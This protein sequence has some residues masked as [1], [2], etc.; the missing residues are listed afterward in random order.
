MILSSININTNR[1]VS[2]KIRLCFWCYLLMLI[3]EGAIRKWFLPGLSDLFLVIRD[4]IVLYVIYLSVK[5]RLLKD[6]FIF[7]NVFCYN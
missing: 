5:Y 6:K 1:S 2:D 7:S 4:P 3:F